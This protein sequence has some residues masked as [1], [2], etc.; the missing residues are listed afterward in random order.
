[1]KPIRS[2]FRKDAPMPTT[3]PVTIPEP[4]ADAPAPVVEPIPEPDPIP[5][6]VTEPEAIPEP[7]PVV[8]AMEPVAAAVPESRHAL[9]LAPVNSKIVVT[10]DGAV[11]VTPAEVRTLPKD[12]PASKLPSGAR[13]LKLGEGSY[14]SVQLSPADDRP[15]LLTAS[16][17]EAIAGFVAH[18]HG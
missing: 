18:F 2:L 15:A 16:A 12:D 17:H 1:M 9:D 11:F 7:E 8:A 3:D 6:P 4:V 14:R 10:E 13:I 5:D